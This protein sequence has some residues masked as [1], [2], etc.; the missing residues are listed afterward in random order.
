MAEGY[1]MKYLK[2]TLLTLGLLLLIAAGSSSRADVCVTDGPMAFNTQS[3]E[4]LYQLAAFQCRDLALTGSGLEA[5]SLAF[6]ASSVY[7]ACTG[8]GIPASVARQAG[9]IG[10]LGIKLIVSNLPC[11][12]RTQQ[13]QVEA[14]AREAVCAHLK[15]QGIACK[16]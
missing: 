4:M 15:K 1:E 10:L 8:V 16:L 6:Q 11:D 13:L 5:V 14:M 12:N 3:D 7:A 2:Q 9:A